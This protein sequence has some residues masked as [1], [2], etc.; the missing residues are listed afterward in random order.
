MYDD[1][2]QEILNKKY[3]KNDSLKLLEQINIEQDKLYQ[4]LKSKSKEN[5]MSF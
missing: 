2:T 5:I 4:K 3:I 1:F